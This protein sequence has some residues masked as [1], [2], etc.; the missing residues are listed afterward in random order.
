MIVDVDVGM[1]CMVY[2][3]CGV[4]LDLGVVVV[5]D[6]FV[7]GEFGFVFWGDGVDVVCCW[8]YWYV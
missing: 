5:F 6:F 8:D 3:D 4:L 1:L 2:C 7:V